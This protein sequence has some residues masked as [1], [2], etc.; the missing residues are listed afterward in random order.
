MTPDSV[1][2]AASWD[3][4][5]YARFADARLRPALDLLARVPAG[6]RRVIYDLGCGAG[7]VTRLLV[8]RYPDAAV[9]GVDSS[10][11]MLERARA[12]LPGPRFIDAD[13]ASWTPPAA[14]DLVVANAALHWVEDHASLMLR[15]L[16]HLRAGGVL[17]VQMPLNHASPSHRA[18]AEVAR[19]GPWAGRLAAVKGIAA[20]SSAA[21]YMRTLAPCAASVDA[22][23]TTYVHALSGADA[24]VEW[25]KGTALRPYLDALGA[26]APAFLADYAARMRT[27]YPPEPDGRTLFPFRRVFIVAVA[28]G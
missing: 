21:D 20:V 26:D 25:T 3:P 4:A 2:G 10:A 5:L 7:Q 8:A 9:T 12:E 27:A 15:L 1:G 18:I 19:A 11:A 14:A 23:E 16:S 22:W 17:A 24:V 28:P 6:P 13:I